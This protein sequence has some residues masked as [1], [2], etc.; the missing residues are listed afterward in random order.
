MVLLSQFAESCLQHYTI[1]GNT[2]PHPVVF[3]NL[4][5][6]PH[7][8]KVTEALDV[9][10]AGADTTASTLTTGILHVLS[11]PDIHAKLRQALNDT[12]P[13]GVQLLELEKIDYLVSISNSCYAR[14]DSSNFQFADRLCQG[15]IEN[16]DGSPRTS[17]TSGPSRS[18]TAFRC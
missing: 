11:S 7:D 4:S 14:R 5:S 13:A 1:H 17:T 18:S 3:D 9:L 8:L 2:T 16:R 6:V 10:I 12:D 15:I